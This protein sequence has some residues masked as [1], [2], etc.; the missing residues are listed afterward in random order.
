MNATRLLSCML[1]GVGNAVIG[2]ANEPT[3]LKSLPPC[4]ALRFEVA[5]RVWPKQVGV[6]HVCLWAGDALAAVSIT[7]D[8]NTAPDH[9]WWLDQSRRYGFQATWFVI[10]SLVNDARPG[11]HG[12]WAAFRKLHGAGHDIQSHTITHVSP[13]RGF[14]PN[15]PAKNLDVEYGMS[16]EIIERHVPGQRVLTLAYPGGSYQ[17]EHTDP[18]L[19]AKY[20]AAARG[21]AG[22]IN[23]ANRVNYRQTSSVG[24][25]LHVDGSRN[26][27]VNLIDRRKS[28]RPFQYRGW[29]VTH[30]HRVNDADKPRLEEGFAFL[31][32][33]RSD[34]WTGLFREVALYGQERDTARIAV[35]SIDDREIRFT[36]TDKML[37]AWYTFPLTIKMRIHGDWDRLEA[38][39]G[40]RPVPASKVEHA[41]NWYALVQV[42]PDRGQVVLRAASSAKADLGSVGSAF[43]HEFSYV[44]T[45]SR[46]P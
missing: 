43:T 24:N 35:D 6:P 46:G 37:D 2:F 29:Y 5:D 19:A 26:S 28:Y 31:K 27:L 33:H 30:F 25:G 3:D 40:E 13:N 16:R 11:Y 23:P 4:D 45:V 38:R 12:N 44:S 9:A 20:Y 32:E 18:T 8:D 22:Q 10:T 17:R 39:Q 14:D 41:G 1:L 34:I 7:I 36:L 21:G 42:V 15:D